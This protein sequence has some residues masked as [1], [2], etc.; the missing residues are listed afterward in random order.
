MGKHNRRVFVRQLTGLTLGASLMPW[1]C[2]INKLPHRILGRTGEKVSLLTLGGG[3]L[4]FSHVSD[5]EALQ[6]IRN[7]I[8]GGVNFLDNA[9]SYNEGR[10]ES[11]MGQI[12]S[13][14]RNRHPEDI[15]GKSRDVS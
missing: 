11:L 5:E 12:L 10:S 4:G 7:A 6:I 1:S 2:N 9:W 13:G 15:G 14:I 3:H 8:D